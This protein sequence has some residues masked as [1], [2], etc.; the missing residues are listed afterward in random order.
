MGI[1]IRGGSLQT[2]RTGDSQLDRMYKELLPEYF[3]RRFC[4]AFRPNRFDLLSREEQDR[5][6]TEVGQAINRIKRTPE[7]LRR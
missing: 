1:S 7:H 3:E 5:L 6:I 4:R 2:I